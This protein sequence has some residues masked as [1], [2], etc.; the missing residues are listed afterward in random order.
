MAKLKKVIQSPEALD[1]NMKLKIKDIPLSNHAVIRHV[2]KV[3]EMNI[4]DVEDILSFVGQYTKDV[5]QADMM[6]T[7]MLPYFGKI[8]PNVKALQGKTKRIRAISNRSYLLELAIRGKNINFVP[9]I[10]PINH[11][12]IPPAA[13]DQVDKTLPLQASKEDM[14][15]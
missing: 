8:T 10:N 2:A 12:T 15:A 3:S 6:E 14:D 9:Q 1:P 4:A 5:I 7:V 13:I 11:A